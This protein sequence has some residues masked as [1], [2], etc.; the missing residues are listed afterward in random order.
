MYVCM[1]VCVC[2]CVYTSGRVTFCMVVVYYT[3][4]RRGG[5][6]SW[7]STYTWHAG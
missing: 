5:L 4:V 6:A 2:V 7:L 3:L 1:C